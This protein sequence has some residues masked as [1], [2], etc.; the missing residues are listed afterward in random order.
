MGLKCVLLVFLWIIHQLSLILY[1]INESLTIRR[2]FVTGTFMFQKFYRI[3]FSDQVQRPRQL[4]HGGPRLTTQQEMDAFDYWQKNRC[5]NLIK[6]FTMI[7][8]TLHLFNLYSFSSQLV[9]MIQAIR[10]LANAFVPSGKLI[11]LVDITLVRLTS[12]LNYVIFRITETFLLW[13]LFKMLYA[14]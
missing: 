13:F 10:D 9:N 14:V 1:S 7:C 12:P 6:Y 4:V 8:H 2:M 11:E 5:K 3:K